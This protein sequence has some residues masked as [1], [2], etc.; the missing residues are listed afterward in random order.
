MLEAEGAESEFVEEKYAN[1]D[2][3]LPD[4]YAD[5][6]G[7]E[8]YEK[9]ALIAEQHAEVIAKT[10]AVY[11]S[12]KCGEYVRP[13]HVASGG[14]L[15]AYDVG[16][17]GDQDGH[18]DEKF[19][20]ISVDDQYFRGGQKQGKAVTECERSDQDEHFHCIKKSVHADQSQQE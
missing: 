13:D 3:D 2:G 16:Y 10:H 20:P 14:V 12:E 5:I 8:G 18:G 15:S 9:F 19:N 17:G 6:K 11:K 4:F 1:D 7:G